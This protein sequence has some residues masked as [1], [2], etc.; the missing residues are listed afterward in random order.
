MTSTNLPIRGAPPDLAHWT[1][2][3]KKGVKVVAVV[4][5]EEVMQLGCSGQW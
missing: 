5:E 4:V 1:F 2:Q 3:E